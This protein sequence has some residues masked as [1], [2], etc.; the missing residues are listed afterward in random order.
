MKHLWLGVLAA[1]IVAVTTAQDYHPVKLWRYIYTP[2]NREEWGEFMFKA[3]DQNGDG[4][5]DWVVLGSGFS[6]DMVFYGSQELDTIPDL[7]YPADFPRGGLG[8]PL[9]DLNGDGKIEFWF[10][11][12]IL[13]DLTDTTELFW[14]DGLSGDIGFR[15]AG[16]MNADGYDDLFVSDH[17]QDSIR[18]LRILLGGEQIDTTWH[19][20]KVVHSWGDTY[21]GDFDGDGYGD[22]LLYQYMGQ[23]QFY[24]SN[25][26]AILDTIPDLYVGGYY[27]VEG[28]YFLWHWNVIRDV[29]GDGKDDIMTV[30]IDL[31][32]YPE[33]GELSKYDLQFF[34]G[35]TEMDSVPDLQDTLLIYWYPNPTFTIVSLGDVNGDGYQ[36]AGLGVSDVLNGIG[37]VL[38]YFGGEDFDL[39]PDVVIDGGECFAANIASAGDPNGNGY[40]D[41]LVWREGSTV[42]LFAADSS[43]ASVA[44]E[45]P[46]PL[47]SFILYPAY[48]NPFNSVTQINYGLPVASRVNMAVYDLMGREVAKL[49]EDEMKAGYHSVLWD[50]KNRS[51]QPAGSGVYFVQIEAGNFKQAKK[52][53]LVR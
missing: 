11:N 34:Y 20:N 21:F 9:G 41:I 48:P 45:Y 13:F 16:D 38:I 15:A 24:F 46:Q 37:T 27:T 19:W 52:M 26:N 1:G 17:R 29:T 22:I 3:G 12:R 25:G 35:G 50:G 5:D 47:S 36:D 8:R 4:Y 28:R 40:D 42:Y 43:F 23:F 51:G 31:D 14:F 7:E 30:A 10:N 6:P 2:Y 18:V 39:E 49:V 44:E 53:T 32:Y 33:I